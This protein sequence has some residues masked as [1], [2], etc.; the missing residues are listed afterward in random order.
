[1]KIDTLFGL[2]NEG[3]AHQLPRKL[4]SSIAYFFESLI[5]GDG[6]NRYRGIAENPLSGLVICKK[7]G[8]P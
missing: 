2:L 6:A 3:I 7:D 4:F 1:V 5:N 8:A